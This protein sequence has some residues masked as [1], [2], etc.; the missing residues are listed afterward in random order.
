[1][2]GLETGK[3]NIRREM[4]P[5]FLTLPEM[6]MAVSSITG[7]R[8][9]RAGAKSARFTLIELLVVIAI[10]AILIAI[11]L[12]ALQAA[13]EM[14]R[15]AVC[16]G[17]L[18]QFGIAFA[19]YSSDFEC[20]PYGPSTPVSDPNSF[21]THF[22][23]D[24]FYDYVGSA[25]SNKKTTVWTCPS[26]NPDGAAAPDKRCPPYDKVNGWNG[27]SYICSRRVNFPASTYYP[28]PDKF[29]RAE[30]TFLLFDTQY[31]GY[32]F[33]LDNAVGRPFWY[34]NPPNPNYPPLSAVLPALANR[35]GAGSGCFLFLDFHVEGIPQR[36]TKTDYMTDYVIH[37]DKNN[38][39]K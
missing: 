6:L 31:Y 5:F 37:L 35:H 26:Q 19:S 14:G 2:A 27:R 36:P 17:N 15:R 11:L 32:P 18:K 4:V 33:D 7:T 38:Y 10:I 9:H 16:L 39:T 21:D 1:M 29:K 8:L 3:K 13:K 12:P 22:T 30:S 34:W 23:G 25:P 24:F 20:L 28:R